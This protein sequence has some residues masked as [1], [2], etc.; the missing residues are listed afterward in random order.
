MS[1]NAIKWAR[2]QRVGSSVAKFV[3]VDLAHYADERGFCWPAQETIAADIESSVDSVQRAI[4]RF[5]EPKFLRRIK[6]KSPDGR[7]ISNGY[8]LNLN[9]STEGGDPNTCGTAP[10]GSGGGGIGTARYSATEPQRAEEPSRIVRPKYTEEIFKESLRRNLR[11]TAG[12]E[13]LKKRLG[14]KA[15]N[16]WLADVVIIGEEEQFLVLEARSRFVANRIAEWYEPQIIE[17]FRTEYPRSTRVRA[18]VRN[19]TGPPKV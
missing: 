5:L 8:Q 1:W 4:K 19:D 15:F 13:L 3:L 16:S 18:I 7:R 12:G 2:K 6:R 11:D 14:E 17:C 10:C 9:V